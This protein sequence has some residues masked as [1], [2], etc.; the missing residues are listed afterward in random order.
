M[1]KTNSTPPQDSPGTIEFNEEIRR[2]EVR[3]QIRRLREAEEKREDEED[4]RETQRKKQTLYLASLKRNGNNNRGASR[5]IS[6]SLAPKRDRSESQQE[7]Q[8]PD[9]KKRKGDRPDGPS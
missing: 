4:A 8:L 9:S 1:S 2:A 7:V 3:K 6:K 5:K